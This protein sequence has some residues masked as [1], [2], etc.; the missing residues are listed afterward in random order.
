MSRE[1]PLQVS[2]MLEPEPEANYRVLSY[3]VSTTSIIYSLPPSVPRPLNYLIRI[4]ETQ[5]L[6]QYRGLFHEQ[7]AKMECQHETTH[8]TRLDKTADLNTYDMA[9]QWFKN[10][11][12]LDTI[13]TRTDSDDDSIFSDDGPPPLIPVSPSSTGDS[14]VTSPAAP[15]AVSMGEP[16]TWNAGCDQHWLDLGL[17]P[18]HLAAATQI[19]EEATGRT[20]APPIAMDGEMVERAWAALRPRE[21]TSEMGAG[22]RQSPDSTSKVHTLRII[23]LHSVRAGQCDCTDGLHSVHGRREEFAFLDFNGDMV[24]K[25]SKTLLFPLS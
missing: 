25:K 14:P 20:S 23:G 2:Q 3:E 11:Q 16:L 10:I 6:R 1:E 13:D 8:T 7:A 21:A 5:I 22:F 4:D 15:T 24:I 17:G 18:N 9:C 12:A 19:H